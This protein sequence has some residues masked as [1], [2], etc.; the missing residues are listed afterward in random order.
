MINING[1]IKINN[2]ESI[3]DELVTEKLIND[4]QELINKE[5]EIIVAQDFEIDDDCID[6][7]IGDFVYDKI[8][9]LIVDKIISNQNYS[10]D[11]YEYTFEYS[12]IEKII[13]YLKPKLN[14]NESTS[15]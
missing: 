2:L 1:Y 5:I 4:L 12:T 7:L 13:N 15:N 6:E 10:I 3:L 9:P 8:E 11:L 14:L